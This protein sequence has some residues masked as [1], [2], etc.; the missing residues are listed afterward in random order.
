MAAAVA[1]LSL[2]G[3]LST[4]PEASAD[5]GGQIFSRAA[6]QK[7]SVVDNTVVIAGPQGFCVDGRATRDGDDSAFVLMASC[8]AITGRADMPHPRAPALLTASVASRPSPGGRPEDRA[9]RLARF[10]SSPEGRAALA[11]DGRSQSVTID[12]MFDRDALFFLHIRDKSPATGPGLK[13]D[14]WRATFEVNGRLVSASVMTF[15][16]TPIATEEQLTILR[17]FAAHI[18]AESARQA[19]DGLPKPSRAP[20]PQPA[21]RGA[22]AERAGPAD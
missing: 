18:R 17:D 13:E 6:P 9:E 16:E 4:G 14:Y 15:A 11:R 21:T 1:S 22:P 5:L 2:S 7:V 8:A 20:T 19:P 12:H 3:C 10:F